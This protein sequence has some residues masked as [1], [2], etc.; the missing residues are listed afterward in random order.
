MSVPQARKLVS[1]ATVSLARILAFALAGGP[2]P[3]TRTYH[4]GTGE[5]NRWGDVNLWTLM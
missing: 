3:T 2:S 4:R 5:V 1:G